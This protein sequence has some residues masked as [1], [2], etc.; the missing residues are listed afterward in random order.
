M[1]SI[2]PSSNMFSTIEKGCFSLG[3]GSLSGGGRIGVALPIFILC[4]TKSVMKN[5]NLPNQ[6]LL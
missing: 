5:I 1:G 2:T 3:K 4:W 6:S